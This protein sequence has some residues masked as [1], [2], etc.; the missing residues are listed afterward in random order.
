VPDIV[1]ALSK[2]KPA[3][4]EQILIDQLAASDVV[5]RATAAQ[6]VGELYG[7]S[8]SELS[9]RALETAS[10]AAAT[11]VDGDARLATLEALALYKRP[12]T[13]DLLSAALKDPI[14]V[15]RR[16]AA[17][18]LEA[19]GAGSF[20]ATLAPVQTGRRLGDYERI[21]TRMR[22]PNPIAT[23]STEKGDVRVELFMRD[24]PLTVANFVELARKKFFDGTVFHRVVPNFVVQGGDPR[25]D[26]NGGP[27]YQIRCEINEIPYD[28]GTVGMALSGKDTGGSQFFFTHAPQPH[29]DGGYTVFG[30]LRSGGAVLDRIVQGDRIVRIT[31]Q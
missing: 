31:I 6:L 25:G 29:L 12:H 27:G 3:G 18:L 4:F 11:D 1:T 5:V 7:S 9:Y 20:V 15:V 10:K 28:R 24:A 21:E 14:Y 2:L 23:I 13:T 8:Q 26:G 22:Q 19:A 17:E 16:R 30:Q